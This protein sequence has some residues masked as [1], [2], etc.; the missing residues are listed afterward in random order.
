MCIKQKE[1][2]R[3]RV[4]RE[5]WAICRVGWFRV[6]IWISQR[7]RGIFLVGRLF[8]GSDQHLKSQRSLSLLTYFKIVY[9]I[10]WEYNFIR[11]NTKVRER[12]FEREY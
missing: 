10:T 12:K 1:G 11:N 5:I 6:S 9:L 2:E 3:E 8:D 4:F 7:Y